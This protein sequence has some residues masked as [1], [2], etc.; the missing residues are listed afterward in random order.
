VTATLNVDT[1][2]GVLNND[3]DANGDTLHAQLIIAPSN[4]SVTLNPDGS[5]SY[6]AVRGSL[7]MTHSNIRRLTDRRTQTWP[8]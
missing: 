2:S 6:T 7:G 1:T 8:K 3:N 4:G 5:F